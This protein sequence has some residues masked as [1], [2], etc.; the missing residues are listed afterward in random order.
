MLDSDKPHLVGIDEDVL[1][2][3]IT[4]YHLRDGAT[5]RIGADESTNDIALRGPALLDEHC[6]I[7]LEDGVATLVPLEGALCMVNAALID[8]PTR[9]SQGCVVVLGKTNMFR[10]VEKR[11]AIWFGLSLS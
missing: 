9:L 8:G 4:L 10:W 7:V 3:G 2:T 1:S 5:T 11:V 6:Q